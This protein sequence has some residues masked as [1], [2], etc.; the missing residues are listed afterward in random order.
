MSILRCATDFQ[1][2]GGYLL[3]PIYPQSLKSGDAD[4]DVVQ[5]GGIFRSS[6]A[7]KIASYAYSCCGLYYVRII[8]GILWM[9][10]IA[11]RSLHCFLKSTEGVFR[12]M[13]IVTLTGMFQFVFYVRIKG[14]IFFFP[15]SFFCMAR[16]F[17][18]LRGSAP[19][20]CTGLSNR[21]LLAPFCHHRY[22]FWWC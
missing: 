12:R 11:I 2:C 1:Q 9:E 17:G 22:L 13:Q 4:G 14:D 10:N 21:V 19:V 5:R 6:T 20:F 18:A 3:C 7:L 8:G 16:V 15:S